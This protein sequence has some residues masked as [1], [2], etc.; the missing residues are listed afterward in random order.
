MQQR[1]INMSKIYHILVVD[2]EKSF[3]DLMVKLLTKQG[4]QVHVA[5]DGIDGLSAIEE[6]CPDLIITDFKMPRMDGI[7][8]LARVWDVYHDMPVIFASSYY[9][10][11]EDLSPIHHGQTHY[12]PK[13]I[14]I[15][16]LF[17]LLNKLLPRES[18][19]LST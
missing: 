5:E 12:L 7:E 15:P 6:N 19:Q 2:D 9:N 3:R 16:L 4:Y 10:Y 13:P 18:T 14:D 1:F 17:E 8:F 11:P